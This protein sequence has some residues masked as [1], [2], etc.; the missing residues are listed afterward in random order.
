MEFLGLLGFKWG[1]RVSGHAADRMPIS[2]SSSTTSAESSAVAPVELQAKSRKLGN[3][4]SEEW[5]TLNPNP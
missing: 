3:K 2:L 1:F 5:L 4:S